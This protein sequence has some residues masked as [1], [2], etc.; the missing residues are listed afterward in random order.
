MQYRKGPMYLSN[1]D[2]NEIQAIR[3]LVNTLSE[4]DSI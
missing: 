3:N 1:K 2:H 4:Q